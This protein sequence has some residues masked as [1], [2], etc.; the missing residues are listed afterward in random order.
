M[1]VPTHNLYDFVNQVTERQFLIK[2]FYPWG[3]KNLKNVIE[4]VESSGEHNKKTYI[5]TSYHIHKVIKQNHSWIRFDPILFCHDQEPLN[6]NLYRDSKINP[7]LIKFYRDSTNIDYKGL[8]LRHILPTSYRKYWILLHSELNSEEVARY[9]DT[10]MF[11]GA[12]WWSHAIIA[13]DWYRFAEY[14]DRLSQ[15]KNENT[16]LFL[17]YSRDTSG[18]RQYRKH[19]FDLCNQYKIANRCLKNTNIDSDS[20][21]IYSWKDIVSTHIHVVLETIFDK[22]IHLTE[23]TLRPIACGQPFILANGPKSLEYLR[24]YGF[25]TFEP[26]I[27]ESYDLQM[28]TQ[29][30]LEAIVLEMIRISKLPKKELTILVKECNQIAEY[31]KKVFFSNE[32][33]QKVVNELKENVESAFGHDKYNLDWKHMWQQYKCDKI[34]SRH[35]RW[36]TRRPYMLHLIK[37]L[38]KGG[39][40]ENYVPPDFD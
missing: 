20:S 37:Y 2:Y 14:D 11:K 10:Q 22:R 31:N 34:F 13:R 12:Y 5:E 40:L 17:T 15:N 36:N 39:T 38:K 18:S 29:Q 28:N 8:N 32:F 30:R 27:N 16:H 7:D 19:F 33:F 21:A 26:W 9:E 1:S 25:K 35:Q 24:S 3:N 6:F 23:K 4:L